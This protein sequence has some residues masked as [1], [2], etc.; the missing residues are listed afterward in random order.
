MLR[1]PSFQSQWI[2]LPDF[3]GQ[4]QGL[5]KNIWGEVEEFSLGYL[6]IVFLIP[7]KKC[8][9]LCQNIVEFGSESIEYSKSVLFYM[10]TS[11]DSWDSGLYSLTSVFYIQSHRLLFLEMVRKPMEKSFCVGNKVN[12]NFRLSLPKSKNHC[13]IT[14]LNMC[15][16]YQNS[17]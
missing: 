1:V 6:W 17:K 5:D 15:Y 14:P 2:Y 8:Y 9:I 11:H 4:C 12:T 10:Y 3:S 7:W 16:S 13:C